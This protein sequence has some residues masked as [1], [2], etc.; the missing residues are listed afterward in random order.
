MPEQETPTTRVTLFVPGKPASLEAWNAA[1]LAATVHVELI[2]NDGEFGRAFG[3]GNV[4]REAMQA[5]DAAPS[6]LVLQCPM[7]LR[8]GRREIVGIVEKLRAAGALAVRIEESKVGWEIAQWLD[9]FSS[10][11][12]SAWHRGAVLFLRSDGALQSCGMHAFSLPDVR[13]PLDGDARALQELA[14]ALNIYELAEDPVL[15]SGQTFAP[16]RETPRRVVERWPDTEYPPTHACHNPFGVW[17]LGP[18]GGAARPTTSLVPTFVPSLQV[19]LTAAEA[20]VGRPLAQKEVE[21]LRNEAPCIALEPRD[22]QHLERKRGYSDI[23]PELVWEQWALV[24]A[25][26]R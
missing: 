22:A 24:R 16:D 3:M 17:R 9:L 7:D 20:K 21:A 15:R 12:A 23:E 26:G 18:A 6:A 13:I 25:S 19:L 14:S 2:P 8:E 10:D 5:I 11:D 4:P 1:A